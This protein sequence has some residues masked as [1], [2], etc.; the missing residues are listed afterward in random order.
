M[1]CLSRCSSATTRLLFAAS[2]GCLES[3]ESEARQSTFGSYDVVHPRSEFTVGRAPVQS[4]VSITDTVGPLPPDLASVRTRLTSLDWRERALSRGG[5]E[6]E[7][8]GVTG[9]GIDNRGRTYVLDG[10]LNQIV[11]FKADGEFAFLLGQTDSTQEPL[12]EPTAF[13]LSS[14][15]DAL[16]GDVGKRLHI[17][18]Q[19]AGRRESRTLK[20]ELPVE[21]LCTLGERVVVHSRSLSKPQ[22]LHLLDSAGTVLRSFGELY[23]SPNHFVN[24]SL[25][26]GL[27][28]CAHPESTILYAPTS[29][30]PELRGYGADGTLR[31]TT[32]IGGFRPVRVDQPH[33]RPYGVRVSVP[34]DGFHRVHS[35]IYDGDGHF[36]VQVA[37]VSPDAARRSPGFDHLYTFAIAA[38]NGRGALVA[39]DVGWLASSRL[40]RDAVIR[41]GV[42]HTV[43]LRSEE[44][45]KAR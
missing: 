44:R 25:S 37:F 41:S 39:T 23:R 34:P 38:S 24:R 1:G 42:T 6:V 21:G 22:L 36:L 32:Q 14:N 5:V 16:V 26:S 12:R 45:G 2:L 27:V 19:Q 10:R 3:A 18:P 9:V 40:D 28:A 8:G 29:A 11:V 33:D 17:I 31:W 7:F 35:A 4:V 15:G 20:L 13:A 43:G 30:L